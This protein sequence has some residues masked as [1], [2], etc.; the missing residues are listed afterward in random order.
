MLGRRHVNVKGVGAFIEAAG[1]GLPRM[2]SFEVTRQEAME[3]FMMVGLRMLRGV[4]RSDF[5]SQ[6]GMSLEEAFGN[7]LKRQLNM[8]L[9]EE[10]AEG[11]RLSERGVLFGNEVFGAFLDAE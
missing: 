10:T 6:F 3:D 11:Y 7:V 1:K 2:E 4:R 9:L 8:G 5:A